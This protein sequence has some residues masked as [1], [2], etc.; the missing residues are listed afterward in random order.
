MRNI[1]QNFHFKQLEAKCR[2][3]KQ[4]KTKLQQ[5]PKQSIVV[6][7]KETKLRGCYVR[8][9]CILDDVKNETF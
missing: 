9:I 1:K 8:L 2:G 5:N 4:N 3:K 6:T 7:E